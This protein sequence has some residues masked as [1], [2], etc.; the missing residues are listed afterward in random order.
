[1]DQERRPFIATYM[2]A[3]RPFGVIYT[4]MTSNLLGRGAQHR[5]RRANSFTA[6]YG[7]D[8]LVW[9]EPHELVTQAIRREKA[10]KR[11]N[12]AWKM[13]LIEQRNPE[14]LDL[15]PFVCGLASDPRVKPEDDGEGS[16]A[17]FLR[18]LESGE[19]GEG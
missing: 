15:Y 8:I 2:T 13:E 9:F 14:W 5:E 17:H 4:G 6:R 7:A 18:R 1:M 16:V 10:I 3:S 11:W 19:L 12:R